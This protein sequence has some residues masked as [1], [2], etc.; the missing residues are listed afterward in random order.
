MAVF[1]VQ[2]RDVAEDEMWCRC[3]R[4]TKDDVAELEKDEFDVVSYVGEDAFIVVNCPEPWDGW[5]NAM[6]KAF[7]FYRRNR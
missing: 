3:Q 7:A 2:I 6:F 4:L 5:Y 1:E